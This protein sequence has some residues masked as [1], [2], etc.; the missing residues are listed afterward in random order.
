MHI[1]ISL[2]TKKD[3]LKNNEVIERIFKD[4]NVYYLIKGEDN[5]E[6]PYL[7]EVEAND[8]S[9]FNETDM[10]EIIKE[11]LRVKEDLEDIED[12]KHI[13]GNLCKR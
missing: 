6:F 8:Y 1:A 12:Q 4:G 11:L 3:F 13:E 9:A 10:G 2:R 5:P 7:S